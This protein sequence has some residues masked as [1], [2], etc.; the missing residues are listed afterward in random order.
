MPRIP[1]LMI[2]IV[3]G[4]VGFVSLGIL[5]LVF[6]EKPEKSV[7]RYENVISRKGDQA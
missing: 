6:T 5:F 3:C 2:W 4:T 1:E 7:E